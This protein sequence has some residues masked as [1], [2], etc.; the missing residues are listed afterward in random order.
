M[1]DLPEGFSEGRITLEVSGDVPPDIFSII[2]SPIRVFRQGGKTRVTWILPD[3]A[4]DMD[5]GELN[6]YIR[7]LSEF[8]FLAAN[9]NTPRVVDVI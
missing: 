5:E 7:V 6:E 4:R 8:L 9:H 3:S 2:L 1:E